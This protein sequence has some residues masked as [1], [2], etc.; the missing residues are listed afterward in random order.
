M[1]ES[2]RSKLWFTKSGASS[3]KHS[4]GRHYKKVHKVSLLNFVLDGCLNG[5]QDTQSYLLLWL[6]AYDYVYT[7]P[8]KTKAGVRQLVICGWVWGL[9]FLD[10]GLGTSLVDKQSQILQNRF[11]ELVINT[12]T[13]LCSRSHVFP[14][15]YLTDQPDIVFGSQQHS[16]QSQSFKLPT[17]CKCK[18][19]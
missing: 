7:Q 14:P 16:I 2:A 13:S 15:H 1:D 19:K 5:W 9:R 10:F 3:G 11:N 12:F 4:T 18:C 8:T 6:Q 17:P